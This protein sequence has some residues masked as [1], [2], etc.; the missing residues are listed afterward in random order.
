MNL[1]SQPS[2]CSTI[3][4]I[5]KDGKVYM[6]IK[7]DKKIGKIEGCPICE[8]Y[9]DLLSNGISISSVQLVLDEK[10]NLPLELNVFNKQ[11]DIWLAITYKSFN[12]NEKI[13]ENLFAF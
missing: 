9:N 5:E 2:N 11:N 12:L 8:K 7:F 13:D 1:K 3:E 6:N 4:N 10:S